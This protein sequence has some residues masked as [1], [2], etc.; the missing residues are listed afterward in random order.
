VNPS[1]STGRLGD[2]GEHGGTPVHIGVDALP[3]VALGMAG[4]AEFMNEWWTVWGF[5]VAV[6]LPLFVFHARRLVLDAW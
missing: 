6:G 4:L 5:L 3:L 1:R 2:P